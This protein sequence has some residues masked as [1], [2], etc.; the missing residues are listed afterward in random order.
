MF[1]ILENDNAMSNVVISDFQKIYAHSL[2]VA[3]LVNG[4]N[5]VFSKLCKNNG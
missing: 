4:G 5:E 3:I 1:N 2:S